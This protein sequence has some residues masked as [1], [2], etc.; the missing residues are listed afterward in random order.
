M[1]GK[2]LDR[3]LTA[4]VLSHLALTFLHGSAHSGGHVL[5]SP[6]QSVFVFAVILIGPVAG[7]AW[8]YVNPLAGGFLA[9]AA[10]AASL[11]FGVVNHFIIISPDHVTQVV[12]EW[13]PLFT[14]SAILLVV[15]EAAGIVAGLRGAFRGREVLS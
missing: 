8:S 14:A 5:L 6:A 4:A 12:A 2:R 9:G 11:V 3:W 1:K 10:M 15:S 13:R 7:L